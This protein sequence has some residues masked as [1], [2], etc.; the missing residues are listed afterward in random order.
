MEKENKIDVSVIVPV[1]NA[2]KYLPECIDSLLKQNGIC[3]E[4]IIIDDGS[5]DNSGAIAEQYINQYNH[6]RVFHQKNMGVSSARNT[7]LR[8]AEGDYVIFVDGDDQVKEN[9]LYKLYYM[10]AEQR[11]DIVIG[12]VLDWYQDSIPKNPHNSVPEELKNSI[13][14]GKDAFIGLIKSRAYH[15]GAHCY[16]FNKYYLERL[17]LRFDES[18]GYDEDELFTSLALC[19][20]GRVFISGFEFY[21]YRQWKGSA[22]YSMSYQRRVISL[23]YVANCLIEFADQFQFTGNNGDL[24]SWLYVKIFNIYFHAFNFLQQVKDTSFVV[25]EFQINLFWRY[26][27]CLSPDTQKIC[28]EHYLN[29]LWRINKYIDWRLSDWVMTVSLKY[30]GNE[31]LLL[32]YNKMIDDELSGIK[33]DMPPDWII[34]TDRKYFSKADAV[35]FYL[36]SLH[37]ETG[38]DIEKSEGQ[39]WVAWYTDSEENYPWLED[40]EAKELFDILMIYKQEADTAYPQYSYEFFERYSKQTAVEPFLPSFQQKAEGQKTHPFIPLMRKLDEKIA[41]MC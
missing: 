28:R 33:E 16:L 4:I 30:T 36:P 41:L 24:K 8:M 19:Q 39:F 7:G 17:R 31:K 13:L 27:T 9:S 2:E 5:S 22:V 6:I 38:E 34:T 15:P 14:S 20:A 11:A 10:S 25:P 12:S 26:F 1:Y 18:I 3:I 21:F 35:V 32:I 40:D 23:I 37:L 29:A